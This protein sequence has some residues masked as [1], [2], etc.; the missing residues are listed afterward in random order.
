M[1]NEA[2][3]FE[4]VVDIGNTRM[5]WGLCQANSVILDISIPHHNEDGPQLL[6]KHQEQLWQTILDQWQQEKK[7][8]SNY[9]SLYWNIA[10]V[11]PGHCDQLIDWLHSLGANIIV[12]DSYT[13][14]PLKVRVEKPES[15]GIDRLLNALAMNRFRRE[16]HFGI[17]VDAGTAITIDIVNRAG[18]FIG[19]YILPGLP[20]LGRSL[21]DYTAKLPWV[22]DFSDPELTDSNL[23]EKP[24][25]DSLPS[26][27]FNPP[28]ATRTAIQRGIIALIS[29]GINKIVQDIQT[30]F[31]IQ[32]G[33]LDLLITGGDANKIQQWCSWNSAV[34]VPQLTLEGIRIAGKHMQ[35][36]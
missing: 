23:L 11:H 12:I 16:N 5:K 8:T 28:G 17:A 26:F 21:H 15:V 35:R 34:V 6:Q 22:K 29:G 13:Q 27:S 19:G 24:R 2:N 18:E 4:I 33:E 32:S 3:I 25:K 31:Q 30:G 14:L 20:L 7:I 10:S 36:G 1:E 9:S